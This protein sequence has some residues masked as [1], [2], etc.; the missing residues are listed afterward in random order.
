[1]QSKDWDLA[2]AKML[3]VVRWGPI[4]SHREWMISKRGEYCILLVSYSSMAWVCEL[5]TLQSGLFLFLC[6]SGFSL[7]EWAFSFDRPHTYFQ[8]LLLGVATVDHPP[9]SSIYCIAFLDLN[10]HL[11]SEKKKRKQAVLVVEEF[12]DLVR[13][14][15]LNGL[16]GLK[17]YSVKFRKRLWFGFK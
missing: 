7:P 5:V 12:R 8:L 2:L 6:L 11:K 14:G 15:I 4:I 3:P 1:M 17:N 16:K 9:P 13:F 10:F